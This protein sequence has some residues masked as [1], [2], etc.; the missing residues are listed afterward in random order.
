M[1]WTYNRPARTEKSAEEQ[2]IRAA[3]GLSP[4]ADMSRRPAAGQDGTRQ[5]HEGHNP[6]KVV[7]PR[8]STEAANHL[9]QRLSN[10]ET[11]LRAEK[12]ERIAA[13]RALAEAQTTIRQLQTKLAHAEIAAAEALAAER[14]AL[15]VAQAKLEIMACQAPHT[16]TEQPSLPRKRGRP[17]G[18]N[19]KKATAATEP[20]PV[21]WWLP[22]YRANKKRRLPAKS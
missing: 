17:P 12:T 14:E 19:S 9:R 10:A 16:P 3:L 22:S 1:S 11:A 4:T 18:V 15:R 13:E 6:S 20:E 7:S 2:Q 5:N 21:K 8:F